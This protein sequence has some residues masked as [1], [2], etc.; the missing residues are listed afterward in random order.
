MSSANNDG[1]NGNIM[2]ADLVSEKTE[3]LG[4]EAKHSIKDY[5]NK[6]VSKDLL[7]SKRLVFNFYK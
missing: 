3:T 5:I 2:I 1:G 4:W 6:I 7:T